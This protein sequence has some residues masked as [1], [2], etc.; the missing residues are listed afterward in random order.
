MSDAKGPRILVA[1][2]DPTLLAIYVETLTELGA[3]VKGVADGAAAVNEALQNVYDLFLL[4]V[5]MPNIDGLQAAR[6]LRG[7][8]FTR[9]TPILI[10]TGKTDKDMIDKA[11]AAGA[12]DFLPKPVHTVLLWQRINNLL[13]LKRAREASR[14]I[15]ESMEV[16]YEEIRR[17][18]SATAILINRASSSGLSEKV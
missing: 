5:D 6:Q 16:A 9:N 7:T 3:Q 11:R 8:A 10:V 15:A 1:D 18:S 12:W 17:P 2:D 13:N 14:D 4:D